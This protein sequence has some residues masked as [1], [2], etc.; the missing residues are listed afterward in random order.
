MSKK[1]LVIDDNEAILDAIVITLESEG[2]QV[3][4][5]RSGGQIY[6]D[7]QTFVP[8]LIL[9]D[10]RLPGDNGGII[11]KSLKTNSRTRHI[12]IIMMSANYNVRDIIQGC[13]VDEFFPK[14]FDIEELLSTVR[15][16]LLD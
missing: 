8:D 15:R 14:P 11:A 4:T 12:P 2:Y 9:L 10:Y 1:L 5:A 7:I 13:G 3:L 6:K 16:F